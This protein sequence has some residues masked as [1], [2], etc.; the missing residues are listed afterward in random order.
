MVSHVYSASVC[1]VHVIGITVETDIAERGFPQ[2]KIVGLPGKSVEEAKERVRTALSNAG[3]DIPA[4]RVIVNLAPADV[5]KQS[6]GFDLPI[7]VGILAAQSLVHARDLEKA[8]FIGE[9]SLNGDI[10]PING[11]LPVLDF[12]LQK[13]F[14]D[15][16]IPY[17]NR[18]EALFTGNNLNIYGVQSM[19][20]IIAHLQHIRTLRRIDAGAISS[21]KTTPSE[22]NI[23][24]FAYVRG[25]QHAKRALEIAA[26]GGHNIILRGPPGTG[27][28]MLAKAF[29]S[30]LP[31]P[32]EYEQLEIAK[33]QSIMYG[34]KGEGL[35]ISRAFRA[36]HHTISRA[37]MIGGG[38]ELTP[39]EVTLAHRGVLFL[40]EFPEFP[41]SITEALRQPIEDGSV[42]I[43]RVHGSVTYPSR[44]LL[45]AAANPCPCGN[46]G[47]KNKRCT[48]TG[49]QIQNY[50]R[51]LS[52]P[53]LDRI[54]IHVSVPNIP[55]DD[56][57]QTNLEAESSRIVRSRVVAAR[58]IQSKR[59]A[60]HT[61]NTYTTNSEMSS[62]DI[63]KIIHLT[64]K[65]RTFLSQ[66][67]QRLHFSPRSYF[68]ILKVAQTIADLQNETSISQ[69][70]ISE[71]V[72]YRSFL[73]R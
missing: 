70:T 41:R 54:D 64:P 9:I 62:Q 17:Q 16:Y 8:L 14:S 50:A 61:Q 39:G 4:R 11:I 55:E 68:K 71:A 26:A 23:H 32:T 24:D 47:N 3:F 29:V 59:F 48:C 44:F 58:E 69:A 18:D 45:I 13:G 7:A 5:P 72:Q 21:P 63:K 19:G 27:K 28:T 37:G 34:G 53:I 57:L 31:P 40:D 65:A 20:D 49:Q 46:N 38:A 66:A 73:Y 10:R 42:T 22:K 67:F 43:T 1:G 60:E 36:P 56:L 15:V 2:L 33:I 12:A 6:S 30:L 52:G 25:Q 51:R 35:S